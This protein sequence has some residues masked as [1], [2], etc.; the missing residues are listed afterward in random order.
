MGR[1]TPKISPESVEKHLLPSPAHLLLIFAPISCK[2]IFLLVKAVEEEYNIVRIDLFCEVSFM[3]QDI[4]NHVFDNGYSLRAPEDT[5]HVYV[6]RGR[7][8]LVNAD[9]NI[10]TYAE[11]KDLPNVQFIRLFAMDGESLYLAIPENGQTLTL[12]GYDYIAFR[13]YRFSHSMY[14]VLSC[15]TAIHLNG[16]YRSNR[17]CGRC[18][19]PTEIGTKER[20]IVCPKCGNLI[21]PRIN[22]AVIVAVTNGERLLMTRYSGRTHN[23][24]H[25]VLVAGFVEIGETA[26]QCV[27][28]EVM[29]EAGLKVKN[30]RYYA[31]QPW[32]C[33]G[34]LTLGYFADLDGD[35]SI[36]ID[37]WELSDGKWFER[38][39]VPVP[40][41]DTSSV[42]ADMIR[43]FAEGREPK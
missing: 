37:A 31:S 8:L 11:L 17:F 36:T 42:T 18:G 13:D 28:R 29:E 24:S 41:W 27:A 3:I 10:P 23:V 38:S 21:F 30:I 15:F 40:T 2:R 12:E 4:G 7:D 33:D 6:F 32:G 22:P 16:W 1:F 34:N 25:Y 43:A 5:N 35:D 39:E 19:H 14:Q 9:K 26:E 20:N